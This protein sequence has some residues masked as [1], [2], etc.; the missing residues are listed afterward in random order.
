M[1]PTS[2][3]A[4]QAELQRL[5]SLPPMRPPSFYIG[6]IFGTCVLGVGAMIG[7]AFIRPEQDNS[8]FNMAIL[9]FLTPVVVGVLGV[10]VK[11]VHTLINS[12]MT[13]LLVATTA[14]ALAQGKAEGVA[15]A[16]RETVKQ[17]AATAAAKVL[18]QAGVADADRRAYHPAPPVAQPA[19]PS[20]GVSVSVGDTVKVLVEG[21]IAREATVQGKEQK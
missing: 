2:L 17:T 16:D 11:D 21:E 9:G 18:M 20:P 7:L 12:R 6:M 3:L 10:M 8:T 4:L 5:R 1:D 19:H 15:E 13:D 14:V